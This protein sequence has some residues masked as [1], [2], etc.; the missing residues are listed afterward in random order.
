MFPE[1]GSSSTAFV[2]QHSGFDGAICWLSSLICP[3]VTL[4]SWN[5]QW[6][7]WLWHFVPLR[8]PTTNEVI[9]LALILTDSAVNR[10][11]RG[12]WSEAVAADDGIAKAERRSEFGTLERN[13]PSINALPVEFDESS[14]GRK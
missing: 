13:I 8:K 11:S 12:H 14:R 2:N 1:S 5:V 4:T 7:S 6:S 3:R 9:E 10:R